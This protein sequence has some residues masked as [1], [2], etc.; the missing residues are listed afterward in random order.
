MP[1]D[2][3][4]SRF[5]AFPF[6]CLVTLKISCKLPA[7]FVLCRVSLKYHSPPHILLI[8]PTP[9]YMVILEMDR[10]SRRR[11]SDPAIGV[12]AA[13]AAMPTLCIPDPKPS[14]PVLEPLECPLP[15]VP[16]RPS[17]G[18][19]C[20]IRSQRERRRSQLAFVL[21]GAAC[22]S[23]SERHRCDMR[24]ARQKSAWLTLGTKRK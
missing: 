17:S 1:T 18:P 24:T 19:C 8:T 11:A 12:A 2:A 13:M 5:S 20:R 23:D 4:H 9:V 3:L 22:L 14:W 21:H 10:I 7:A 15:F 16:S 6:L